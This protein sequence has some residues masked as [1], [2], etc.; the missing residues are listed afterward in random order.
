M[1]DVLI[2]LAPAFVAAVYYFGPGAA[3]LSIICVS[4]CVFFEWAYRKLKGL[5]N[6]VTDLS[7]VVTG[8]LLALNLP[9]SLPPW[10]AVIGC[11]VAIVIV[12]QLFGGIGKNIVNP[13]IAAR[14]V[15]LASFK[16]HMLYWPPARDAV[17]GATPLMEE[18]FAALS[19]MDLLIGRH[20]G[21][22]GETCVAALI[23]GGIYLVCRG[24]ITI[25]TPVAFLGAVAAMS[26]VFGG[27]PVY[28]V[29]AGGAVL[30][31]VFMATDY[32]TSPT[33]ERGKLIFGIGCGVLTVMIRFFSDYP[34]GVSF[35]IL[36][37]NVLTPLI[38]RL[39]PIKAFGGAKVK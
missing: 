38:D 25:T 18:S 26:A 20:G 4:A 36:L 13:A 7:A 37:M 16:G 6:T 31:A 5:S 28:Q 19:Y 39:T 3:L 8:L 1:R 10:I 21:S 34:E 2:A 29:L 14:I 32:T 12:K 23:L 35:A 22:M 17:T 11:F 9:S 30:G 33:A 15:L 27:D 24:V